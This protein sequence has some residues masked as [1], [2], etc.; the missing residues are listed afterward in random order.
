MNDLTLASNPDEV[1]QAVRPIL[2][3]IYEALETAVPN[4]SLIISQEGWEN[5]G[6]LFSHLVRADVKADLHGRTCPIEFDDIPRE[7]LMDAVC[8][9]GLSTKF[10]DITIKIFKG[11]VLPRPTSTKRESFYQHTIPGMNPD[12]KT[13]QL[14]SLVVLWDCDDEGA[15]LKLWLCCPNDKRG[16][17][18]WREVVPH[19]SEWMVV[20][21]ED[22]VPETADE[23]EELLQGSGNSGKKTTGE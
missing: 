4:A 8:N 7:V 3:P 5:N 23:F 22:A 18:A 21:V 11:S 2:Q 15:S 10:E 1:L 6:L 20:S 16:T 19:P 17:Y 9:D 13:A 12:L 14:R